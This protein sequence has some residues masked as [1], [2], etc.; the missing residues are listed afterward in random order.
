MVENGDFNLQFGPTNHNSTSRT[1]VSVFDDRYR[2]FDVWISV[3]SANTITV[4]LDFLIP[5]A[6]VSA[7][8]LKWILL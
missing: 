3:I 5:N 2:F 6:G 8:L 7:A 4:S 1:P